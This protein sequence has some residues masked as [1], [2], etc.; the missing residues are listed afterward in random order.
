MYLNG[1]FISPHR[2][3]CL[4]R[5]CDTFFVCCYAYFVYFTFNT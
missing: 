3:F 4:C 1:G 5:N 2:A